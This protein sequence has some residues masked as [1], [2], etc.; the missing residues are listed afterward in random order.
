MYL[1][2]ATEWMTE[3]RKKERKKERK[4]K[5]RKKEKTKT[6][7]KMKERKDLPRG[8]VSILYDYMAQHFTIF[9]LANAF[10]SVNSYRAT[11]SICR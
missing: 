7:R 8:G 5:E 6:K 10:P 2:V 3:E 9:T 1:H 4:R 11:V